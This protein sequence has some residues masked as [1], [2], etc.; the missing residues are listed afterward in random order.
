M[1]K[2]EKLKIN[3]GCYSC[4][5][6]DNCFLCVY[7]NDFVKKFR[8]Y[9]S[10]EFLIVITGLKSFIHKD[11]KVITYLF[12]QLK[13]NNITIALEGNEESI[14][15]IDITCKNITKDTSYNFKYQIQNLIT[16]VEL[17]SKIDIPPVGVIIMKIVAQI[18]SKLKILYKAIVLDLDDTL[19]KGTL[20]EVGIYNIREYMYSEEG[21]PFIEFMKFLKVLG[22]ELGVFITICSRNDSKMIESTIEEFD[23]NIFPLKNQIDYIIANNND[24]SENIRMIAEQLSILPSSIV[25]IDDNQ[26]V[27]D[28]V[29]RKLTGVFV[30]EWEN[31]NE[32]VTKLIAGCI[33]ERVELSLNSQ[34]RRKQY[35]IIQAERKQNFL[36]KLSVKVID[37]NK[38]TESIKLYSKSNQFKFSRNDDNLNDNTKSLY[39]EIIRENGE[40]LGI[41]SA[42]TFSNTYD[43]FHIHNWAISC[44]YFEIGLEEFI[45]LY[46]QKMADTN[47]ILIN[48]Q[49][50]EYNQKVSEMLAKYSD[51]FKNNG[52]KDSMEIIFTKEIVDNIN[53]NTNLRII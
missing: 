32:L 35:K 40:N 46:I 9:N 12:E 19:W 49:P 53:N 27:R 22:N 29:K 26:I 50:S 52:K 44:R 21:A 20:S 10:D 34:N 30:P 25:F 33:F 24:K 3:V 6:I 13:E 14:N 45:L 15:Q 4:Q 42:I 8:N 11:E 39:F 31:H 16:I 43:T 18:I 28:E 17:S 38:H 51:A 47:T 1:A 23:D 7:I 5:K 36:P 41:C 37:D 48:H 2:S